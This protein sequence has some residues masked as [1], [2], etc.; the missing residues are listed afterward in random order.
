VITVSLWPYCI[1]GGPTQQVV[2]Q[3][4]DA[5]QLDQLFEWLCGEDTYDPEVG[6]WLHTLPTE[7]IDKPD[8]EPLISVFYR[9]FRHAPETVVQRLREFIW[10][11]G[12]NGRKS[13]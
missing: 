13:L 12:A 5:Y 8:S 10:N 2:I 11:V 9:P 3:K 1:V 4:I 7:C 6:L